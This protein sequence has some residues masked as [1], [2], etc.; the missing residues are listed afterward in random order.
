MRILKRILICI[1]LMCGSLSTWA[2]GP[3]IFNHLGAGV[4][5]GTTGITLDVATP[6]TGFVQMR[7][8]VDFMV[9]IK[10]HANADVE[11]TY[12]NQSYT[13]DVDLDGNLGRVQGKVIFNVYPIPRC[14][15]FVG[16]GG[17]FGGNDL[18][19]I[20]GHCADLSQYT[21]TDGYVIIGD[22]QIPIDR[23]GDV[24]GSIRV[25]GF[26]PYFSLGYGR[27][28]PSKLLNFNVELGVQVHGKP[29]LHSKYGD[30]V[31]SVYEDDDTFSKIMDKVRVYPCLTFRLNFRAF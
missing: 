15:F 14:S 29:K 2:I 4:G 21:S 17:Y 10:F 31:N 18:V 26:R 23:N 22:Q 5:I 11:Y 6:I 27:A 30:V 8:G 13:S 25:N 1:A 3:D 9:P 19:R 12:M 7:A 16:V 28:V 24:D 20:K